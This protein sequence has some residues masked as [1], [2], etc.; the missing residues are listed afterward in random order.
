MQPKLGKQGQKLTFPSLGITRQ[1]PGAALILTFLSLLIP[2][3]FLS[4]AIVRLQHTSLCFDTAEQPP[5]PRLDTALLGAAQRCSSGGEPRA[6]GG[7]SHPRQMERHCSQQQHRLQAETLP[8]N[9]PLFYFQ[10]KIHLTS[11]FTTPPETQDH[12]SLQKG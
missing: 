3:P 12:F 2:S 7:T 11:L 10:L 1:S 4:T 5:W 8:L 9:P 6:G